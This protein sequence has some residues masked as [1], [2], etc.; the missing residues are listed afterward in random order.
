MQ[1]NIRLAF[2]KGISARM[3]G[4]FS[5]VANRFSCMRH[6]SPLQ[7]GL[8]PSWSHILTGLMKRF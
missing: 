4:A 2:P 6:L 7:M 5:L 8:E 1:Q 3:M